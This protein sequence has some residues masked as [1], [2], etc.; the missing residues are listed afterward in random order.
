VLVN[1][2]GASRSMSELV[3]EVR[4]SRGELTVV[5][6]RADTT[7]QSLGRVSRRIE[8]GEGALGRL[9]TSDSLAVQLEGAAFNLRALL[10]DM[11][12]N[13]G[14]YIRLSIF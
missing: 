9:L 11:R 2:R 3:E 4:V 5:L 6:A 7:L 8:S 13:P 10:E 12:Q 1:V 14:R